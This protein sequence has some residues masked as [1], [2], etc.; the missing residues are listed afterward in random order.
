MIITDRPQWVPDPGLSGFWSTITKPF[1]A[2]AKPAASL[3]K[4]TGA[5]VV[6]T[7]TS[8]ALARFGGGGSAAAPAASAAGKI[9]K[10]ALI[11][12][13]VVLGVLLFTMMKKGKR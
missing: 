10:G 12:G 11:G 5:F 2:V 9:P 13:A 1:K 7:A 6:G 4:Q 3:A 8:A